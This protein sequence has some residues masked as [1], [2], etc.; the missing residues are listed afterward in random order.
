MSP[1]GVPG[2]GNKHRLGIKMRFLSS[3][4][5]VISLSLSSEAHAYLDPGTGSMIISAVVGIFAT[6][7]LAAKTYW[8][9]LTGMFRRKRQPDADDSDP[10]TVGRD[11][12]PGLDKD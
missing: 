7:A 6:L 4:L 11:D 9:K 3:S 5:L 1:A 2:I 12:G 8:Y 10:V